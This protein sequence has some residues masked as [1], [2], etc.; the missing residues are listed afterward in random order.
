MEALF[1]EVQLLALS[2]QEY[3]CKGE[4]QYG[5]C[6][7]NGGRGTVG[8]STVIVGV[9]CVVFFV[10]LIS[11]LLNSVQFRQCWHSGGKME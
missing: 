8:A 5:Y 3:I 6:G 9:E 4:G 10:C 1:V 7:G 2:L 11:P